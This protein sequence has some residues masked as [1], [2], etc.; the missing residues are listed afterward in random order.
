MIFDKSKMGK[1]LGITSLVPAI[2]SIVVFF[3][4]RGPN[5]DI[6]FIIKIC[7]VLSIFGISLAVASS[8][9]S[10]RF[11]SGLL[12]LIVNLLVLVCAFLLLLAMGISES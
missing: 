9:M 4:L 5:A 7:I 11:F 12:G 1:F 6:Y 8:M 10:K 3:A 2:I